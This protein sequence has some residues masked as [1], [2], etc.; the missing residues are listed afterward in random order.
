MSNQIVHAYKMPVAASSIWESSALSYIVQLCAAD[1][2]ALLRNFNHSSN[3]GILWPHDSKKKEERKKHKSHTQSNDKYRGL[4]EKREE[5]K[6]ELIEKR[7]NMNKT[8]FQMNKFEIHFVSYAYVLM[9]IIIV[10][11]ITQSASM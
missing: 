3:I 4:C 8:F 2:T 7:I 5:T 9:V 10:F 1:L 6:Q 11:M